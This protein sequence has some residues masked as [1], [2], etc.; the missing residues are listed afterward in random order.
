MGTLVFTN[1][2]FDILHA[3]HVDF[4]E[5]AR[6]LGSRL[7]VGLN[8]D[9]S[10]RAIKGIS[11]PIVPQE[12]RLAVL[13]GLRAVDDVIVFDDATPAALIEELRPDVLVKGGD[14]EADE[15][16][17]GPFVESIGGRVISLTLSGD[18]STSWIIQR[19][20]RQT[21]E[22]VS[23]SEVKDRPNDIDILLAASLSEHIDVM[24]SVSNELEPAIR[25]C[26]DVLLSVLRRGNKVLVCG[27]GGSAAD[28]QHLA[29]ELVGRYE[30]ER[31]PLASVALTT[32]TSAL[33]AIANDF[34]FQYIFSRQVEALSVRG[35]V[36]IAL[37]TSGNSPNIT[38]AVMSARRV[39][40]ETIGLTG[41][42]GTKLAG[43]C[44]Y[45]IVVPSVRTAR[46]QEAH[47]TIAH[48]WCEIIERGLEGLGDE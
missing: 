43:I 16:V 30:S 3:G 46:I 19:I 25:E 10:V 12:A 40:C 33:T 5:R 14:W 4:L 1:G 45:C 8:S 35:D 37:S 20:N 38:N 23:D 18:L 24:Q 29:A 39:G 34:G 26:A 9:R 47:I 32:D 48:I 11:R 44:D 2:C 36:L 31:R 21:G 41:A 15:I 7:V 6:G 28:A 42:N 22:K 27:N 17:G 13:R